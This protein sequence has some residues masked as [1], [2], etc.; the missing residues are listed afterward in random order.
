MDYDFGGIRMWFNEYFARNTSRKIRAVQKAKGER[1]EHLSGL[2]PYGYL[3]D[4][5]DPK[6]WIVDEEAAKV[7]NQYFYFVAAVSA[8]LL[9]PHPFSIYITLTSRPGARK[10]SVPSFTGFW[11]MR[12]SA[13]A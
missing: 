12:P 4:P 3:K 1:G 11:K 13:S 8:I 6:K 7:V 5:N 2:V 10:Y 9:R